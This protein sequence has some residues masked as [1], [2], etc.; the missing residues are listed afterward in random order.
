LRAI[1]HCAIKRSIHRG[2][3]ELEIPPIPII[4]ECEEARVLHNL[5]ACIG[6]AE[7][8]ICTVEVVEVGGIQ[9]TIDNRLDRRSHIT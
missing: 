8:G 9:R 3:L 6:D 7:L 2:F 4:V 5:M 1:F